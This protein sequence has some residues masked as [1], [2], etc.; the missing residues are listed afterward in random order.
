[1][2]DRLVAAPVG[3]VLAALPVVL[4]H[5]AL[6]LDDLAV[7]V[8]AIIVSGRLLPVDMEDAAGGRRDRRDGHR[9]GSGLSD[10]AGNERQ[11]DGGEDKT[12]HGGTPWLSMPEG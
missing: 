1:V 9:R 10:R 3:I 4:A 7:M 5:L 6:L 11:G 8:A 2:A 12:F